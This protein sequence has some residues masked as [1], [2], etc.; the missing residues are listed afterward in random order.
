LLASGS[1]DDTIRLWKIPEGGDIPGGEECL[2]E[3]LTGH[4]GAVYSVAFSLDGV[5]LASSSGIGTIK[6]W[7]MTGS[8]GPTQGGT[9][10]AQSAGLTLEGHNACVRAVAFSPDGTRLAS[11]SDDKTVK[12]WEIGGEQSRGRL[13]ETLTGHSMPI[14]AVA[15]SPGNL[16]MP[17]SLWSGGLLA[18][19]SWD[20][21]I[22]L[23][24]AKE[25]SPRLTLKDNNQGLHSVAFSPDG[26]LMAF[27]SY[28][29][30]KVMEIPG[31]EVTTV[32]GHEGWVYSVAFSPD[33][34]MLASASG[35]KTVKLWGLE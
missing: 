12:L 4:W 18:S 9:P 11:A 20:T 35:D 30:I 32:T 6:L 13:V 23:W 28:H 31:G 5:F 25:G 24:D 33:G 15:F 8:R 10:W 22:R 26:R 2:A 34:K 27:S 14:L 21:T 3:T 19:A 1:Y 17:A 29:I 16:D 7:K